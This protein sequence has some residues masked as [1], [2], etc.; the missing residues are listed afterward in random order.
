MQEDGFVLV[1]TLSKSNPQFLQCVLGLPHG[2]FPIKDVQNASLMRC[3][4]D[5][6][7]RCEP[8]RE[9]T[10]PSHYAIQMLQLSIC[11]SPTP[12]IPSVMNKTLRYLNST[13]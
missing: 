11:K 10:Y 4:E 13:T 6:L 8:P 9:L 2:L 7:A 3:P 5:I 1:E 12:L